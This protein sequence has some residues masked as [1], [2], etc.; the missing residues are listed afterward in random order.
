MNSRPL[1][2]QLRSAEIDLSRLQAEVREFFEWDPT[3]ENILDKDTGEELGT[4]ETLP[5]I[6]AAL[7]EEAKS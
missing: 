1:R 3:H 7:D 5:A 2:I 6:A 4:A